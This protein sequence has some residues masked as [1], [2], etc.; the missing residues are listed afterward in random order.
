MDSPE[1]HTRVSAIALAV[2]FTIGGVLLG[3]VSRIVLV[4]LLV[5]AV[6][7]ALRPRL[8]IA[9]W[10]KVAAI[11][12][13][14]PFYLRR[15]EIESG[16]ATLTLSATGTSVPRKSELQP[17]PKAVLNEFRERFPE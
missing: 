14:S 7:V 15:A 4:A 8:T 1:L 12:V 13:R 10:M 17:E 2:F 6:L 9:A 16:S 3:G 11:R 5:I